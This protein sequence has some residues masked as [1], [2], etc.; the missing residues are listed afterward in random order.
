[1]ARKRL[2]E[3]LV[4]KKLITQAQ[5]DECLEEQKTTKEY[6]GGMLVRKKIVGEEQL[7]RALS[8]QFNIPFVRL[9]DQNIDWDI[10]LK[11]FPSMTT[12]QNALAIHSDEKTVLVAVRDPLDTIFL[13]NIEFA[14]RPLSLKLVLVCESDLQEFIKECHRRSRSS[15]KHL[16]DEA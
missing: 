1:M 5:L 6:L 9:R 4:E 3:I 14:A 10:C 13:S 15:L 12:N 11:Y 2:G 16:L 8:E 7:M